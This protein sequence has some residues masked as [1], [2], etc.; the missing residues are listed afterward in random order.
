MTIIWPAGH[1]GL[2]GVR[3]RYNGFP[4]L[5]WSQN[6]AF[7]VDSGRERVFALDLVVNTNIVIETQNNDNI[8]HTLFFTAYTVELDADTDIAPYTPP[9][10]EVV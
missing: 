1:A 8:A 3:L 4:I 7:V 5:P 6:T 10:I 9:T 2:V